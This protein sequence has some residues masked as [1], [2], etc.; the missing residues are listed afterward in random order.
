VLGWIVI[1]VSW[2]SEWHRALC[3]WSWYPNHIVIY[4]AWSGALLIA[5]WGCVNATCD[6][7][8]DPL[9]ANLYRAFFVLICL[10]TV[11]DWF[12][13]F[14]VRNFVGPIITNILALI[15]TSALIVIFATRTPDDAWFL[16]PLAL[17]LGYRIQALIYHVQHPPVAADTHC[18]LA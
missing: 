17:W 11:A 12:L 14:A 1:L 6:I 9:Y 2:C 5:F 4:L 16:V 7:E 10:F 3:Y 13:F 18:K 8:E 15:L